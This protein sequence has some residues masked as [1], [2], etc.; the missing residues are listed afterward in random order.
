[1]KIENLKAEGFTIYALEIHPEAEV[2]WNVT[3]KHPMALIAGSE[4]DGISEEILKMCDK[5]V[6]IPMAGKKESLNVATA[7]G[8]VLYEFVKPFLNK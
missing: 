8:I 6:S 4:V 3:P 1:M 2:F 7:T 5:I